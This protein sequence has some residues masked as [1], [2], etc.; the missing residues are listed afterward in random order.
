MTTLGL[1]NMRQIQR[2]ITALEEQAAPYAANSQTAAY[3]QGLSDASEIIARMVATAS[4]ID[5]AR[6]AQ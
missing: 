3:L 6:S 1:T 4:I 2:E 5:Y